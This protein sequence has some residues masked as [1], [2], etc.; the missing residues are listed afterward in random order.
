MRMSHL[1]S[2]LAWVVVAASPLV[3]CSSVRHDPSAV[4]AAAANA[5]NENPFMIGRPLV[6]PHAG[7][8]AL[9]PENTLYAY[10]HSIA[11]GG[12]VVDAD[13]FL[14]SDGIPIAFHDGTLE[15]TTNGTGRVEDTTLD[16]IA[17]LDAAWNFQ[18]D[19]QF[20]LR[21]M[22]I[23]VPTI[24]SILTSFPHTLTTLDLKDLRPEAVE[25]IC[26]LLTSL[27]RTDDVYV[28]VDTDQQVM[29]FRQL[30]PQVHTSAT[31][32]ERQAIRAA[33]SAG[34]TTF[35]SSQLV[36]QPAFLAD[37]G[38]RRITADY[39]AYSHRLGIAVM[40]WVVD[41][42]SDMT[43]LIEM[44]V[45]GIYTRRP[46]LMIQLLQDMGRT[47]PPSTAR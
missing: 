45:D 27:H 47:E 29:I 11:M 22:G 20:P 1:R 43:D 14:T 28:G 37:D 40:T 18:P 34:D 4:Q 8:D 15:R 42:P 5:P 10:E 6:I 12:D 31:S 30:C 16:D 26:L 38:T 44:G 35:V 7:G 9:F 3:G 24:E 41:D 39:L 36:G 13:V 2:A 23:T 25:P 17:D 32:A 19:Q 21:G 33:R 46:D